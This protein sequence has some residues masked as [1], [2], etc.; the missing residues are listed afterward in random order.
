MRLEYARNINENIFMADIPGYI[1]IS[2]VLKILKWN[3][4]YIFVVTV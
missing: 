1:N 4:V 2:I 3:A